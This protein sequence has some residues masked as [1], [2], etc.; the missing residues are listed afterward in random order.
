[1]TYSVIAPQAA[2]ATATRAAEAH[3]T[4][5]ADWADAIHHTMRDLIDRLA[6]A[7]GLPAP[8]LPRPACVAADA[9]LDALGPL[10]GWQVADLG[11]IHQLLL[12]LTP[13]SGRDGTVRATRPHQGRRDSQGAWYTPPEVA[14][15]MS[16]LSIGLAI[17]GLAADEDP[18]AIFDLAVI[19]PACGAGVLLVD[20]ARYIAGRLAARVSGL[21][22][23]PVA[24][25]RAGLPVVMTSC[26]YGVDI[27]PVAVDLARTALW[28]EVGGREPFGFMDRNVVVGNAL[29]DVL[30][31]AF[32]ERRGGLPAVA[33]CRSG[34]PQL[35]D[36]PTEA[37]AA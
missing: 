37:G 9:A 30:P 19:D 21:D 15:A 10:D 8:N 16:R 25:V 35:Y 17:D 13:A 6:T 11:E 12:E 22:P 4:A 3:A 24:H 33:D 29:D 27:D 34:L 5:G 7:H 36:Q 20:S 14:A 1:V 26:I 28:L 23:A 32:V 18:G 31:P 2:A